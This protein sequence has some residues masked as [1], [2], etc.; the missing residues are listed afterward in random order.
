MSGTRSI[1]LGL[2]I[3]AALGA[4]P[5][6]RAADNAALD[7]SGVYTLTGA[8]GSLKIKKASSWLLEVVQTGED[9]KV[10]KTTDGKTTT[11]R[12]L[13]DGTEGPY[14]SEGGIK[15][16]CTARWKGKTLVIDTNVVSSP[17]RGRPDVRIHTREQWTL[18][19]DLKTLTIRNDVDFPNS[20]L[21]GFQVIEPWSEIYSRN[22]Q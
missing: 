10:A 20:G 7:F 5:S 8:K 4:I 14:I 16:V 13:R 11:N 9:I 15:G 3:L 21:G 22:L 1:P 12:F 19:S 17:Q 18:S 6:V 2:V